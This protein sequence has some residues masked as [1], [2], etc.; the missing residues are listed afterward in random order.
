MKR[1]LE[2]IRLILTNKVFLSVIMACF[3]Y[4]V[5]CMTGVIKTYDIVSWF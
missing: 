5:A 2:K 1:F 3:T 4:Y